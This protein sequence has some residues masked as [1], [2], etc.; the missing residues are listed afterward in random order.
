MDTIEKLINSNDFRKLVH[1]NDFNLFSLFT[2]VFNENSYTRFLA[3]F[4][5]SEENHGLDQQFFR[6]WIK[7]I[8]NSDFQLPTKNKSIIKTAFNW[9]THD[10]RFIDMIIQVINK[11]SGTVTHVIGIEN[12]TFSKE[13]ENQLS[14][15]QR[16]IIET[17][18]KSD[19]ALI[20]LTPDGRSGETFSKTLSNQC[21]CINSSYSSLIKTCESKYRT[22]NE[23]VLSII[24]HLR[25]FIKYNLIYGT[26]MNDSKR[27]IVNSIL[28]DVEQRMA[29]QEIIKYSPCYKTIRNLI[30]EDVLQELYEEHEYVRIAWLYPNTSSTPHEINFEINDL[31][32]FV[33]KRK[34]EFYYMLHSKTYSPHIGDEIIVRLM[35]Y[36]GENY[37][38]VKSSQNLARRIR[39]A[40]VFPQNKS[41]SRE[42]KPWVCLY[43]GSA[44][45]LAD[46]GE[47]DREGIVDIINECVDL[48]Y[49]PLKRFVQSEI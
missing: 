10:K 25:N 36:C 19:K 27:K 6:T 34:I 3:Y 38:Y 45:N 42:W 7:N 11:K 49:K 8:D 37:E 32:D 33:G 40:G 44:Y 15:Y 24:K 13:S 22:E 4:L 35:A 14:D 28:K 17:F 21:P 31:N 23:E 30:Y 43:S 1:A 20:Y 46:M 5:S 16:D 29:V 39:K 12:K 26:D 41:N 2:E 47:L 18:P 48:T 9:M